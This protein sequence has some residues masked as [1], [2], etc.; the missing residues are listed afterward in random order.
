MLENAECCLR[1]NLEFDFSHTEQKVGRGEVASSQPQAPP[2]V[3]RSDL[4]DCL[5]TPLISMA[6]QDTAATATEPLIE[7]QNLAG[8]APAP[9]A[10]APGRNRREGGRQRRERRQVTHSV[11]LSV[12]A[13]LFGTAQASGWWQSKKYRALNASLDHQR[14]LLASAGIRSVL[15][16]HAVLHWRRV[17]AMLFGT[18][19]ASGWWQSKKYRRSVLQGH[20]VLHWRGLNSRLFHCFQQED[21]NRFAIRIA[22]MGHVNTL[23]LGLLRGVYLRLRYG[24]DDSSESEDTD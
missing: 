21:W 4:I 3:T 11:D 5:E 10:P 23:E 24:H 13:M 20:A 9:A 1:C 17:T 19:E 6:N 7:A 14:L 22:S 16:G 2:V 18:A 15:Q 12:K 8:E